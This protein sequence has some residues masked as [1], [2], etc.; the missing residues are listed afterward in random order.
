MS[1]SDILENV[2][3][4]D[5]RKGLLKFFILKMLD[6]VDMHG[7]AM[8]TKIEEVSGWKVSPGSL[9]PTLFNLSTQGFV[10]VKIVN[11]RKMFSLTTKGKN[12]IEQINSNFETGLNEI[13]RI[14]NEL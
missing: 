12:F 7:Y 1:K 14:F 11:M 5:F 4:K 3:A 8:M 9:Y 13:N 6:R 10:K 2:I